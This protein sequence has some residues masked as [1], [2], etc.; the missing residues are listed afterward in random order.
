MQTAR[1]LR[2]LAA[3]QLELEYGLLEAEK[4]KGAP[5]LSAAQ[6]EE[7][8]T[9][10]E[11]GA[12]VRAVVAGAVAARATGVLA[13]AGG[14]AG[15]AAALEAAVA[16]EVVMGRGALL[17]GR[18]LDAVEAEGGARV[19]ARNAVLYT[20]DA[21]GGRVRVCGR[22]DG[23]VSGGRGR[24]RTVEVTKR[25]TEGGRGEGNRTWVVFPTLLNTHPPQIPTLPPQ[26]QTPYSFSLECGTRPRRRPRHL[27]RPRPPPQLSP[28]PPPLST[29]IFAAFAAAAAAAL[30][31]RSTCALTTRLT[32]ASSA[33][34]QRH[35]S[36]SC[37]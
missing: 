13:A 21:C 27:S 37:W 16:R 28:P 29:S 7:D 8:A 2:L 31:S 35:S 22:V 14:D 1:A 26:T 4:K 30:A 24:R 34:A 11:G 19:E 15:V 9:T 6:V 23:L 18:A 32:S 25:A 17:K 3:L 12:A 33:S 20:M 36:V 5:R 10:A